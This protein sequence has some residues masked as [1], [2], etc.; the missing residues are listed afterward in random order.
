MARS[1]SFTEK[2][3]DAVQKRRSQLVMRSTPAPMTLPSTAASTGLAHSSGAETERS[4][5]SRAPGARLRG[6]LSCHVGKDGEVHARTKVFARRSKDSD[7][8]A[9]IVGYRVEAV[10]QLLPRSHV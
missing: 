8:H 2:L 6:L 7:T 3:V 5:A 10:D 9:W 1:T 4:T